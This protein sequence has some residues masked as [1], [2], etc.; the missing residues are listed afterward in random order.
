MKRETFNNAHWLPGLKS[1]DLMIVARLRNTRLRYVALGD[2]F[3][4]GTGSGGGA[5]I[6]HGQDLDRCCFRTGNAY[7][8]LLSRQ[9]G[10]SSLDFRACMGARAISGQNSVLQQIRR[11]RKDAE[12][13]TVT[14]G[15]HDMGISGVLKACVTSIASNQRCLESM[16]QRKKHI[17]SSVSQDIRAL[18]RAL[19]NH[20]PNAT[21]LFVG[22]PRP[23]PDH[24]SL[25]S[26]PSQEISNA[27]NGLID[28]LNENI[29]KNVDNFVS[30]SFAKHGLCAYRDP[31][32]NRGIVPAV[33]LLT[34][35]KYVDRMPSRCCSSRQ[36]QMSI[37]GFYRL[38]ARG[39]LEYSHSVLRSYR[40]DNR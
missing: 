32:M 11:V 38:T 2:S 1:D 17:R 6:L 22:Y 28:Y 29:R 12:L 7:P 26:C 25:I 10:V 39:S 23:Y 13:V 16:E 18:N 31:W 37:G 9:L 15:G 8:S 3:A 4:A 20:F 27:A 24:T 21:I 40:D 33:P 36:I 35:F 14:V 5:A 34:K 19:N 30:V